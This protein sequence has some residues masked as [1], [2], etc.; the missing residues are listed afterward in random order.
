M[1]ERPESVHETAFLLYNRIIGNIEYGR[2]RL[3]YIVDK[4]ASQEKE[5]TIEQEDEQTVNNIDLTPQEVTKALWYL[6]FR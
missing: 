6:H 3:K 1:A 2:E 5:E 4:E